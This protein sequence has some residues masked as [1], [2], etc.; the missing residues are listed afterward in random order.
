MRWLKRILL[1]F[2]VL[3]I[4]YLLGPTPTTPRYDTALSTLPVQLPALEKQVELE[5]SKQKLKPGNNATIVW[6]DSSYSK[7][8]YAIVYLHGFS[9]SREEGN[10]VHTTIAKTF[11]CNLYLSR[12]A[13]HGLD[14]IEPMANLTAEQLWESAKE[15]YNIG[16]QLGNKVILMGTSTGG[17][18]ALQLAAMYPEVAGL[19]LMSPN[20]AIND[21][22][23]WLL[24]NPW[25][26]QIARLVRGSKN[27][28]ASNKTEEYK[29]YW[30]FRYRLESA[31]ELQEYLETAMVPATFAKIKQ[32]VLTLYY[33]KDEVHQDPVVKVLAMQ[34]MM[35][36]LGTQAEEKKEVA[37]PNG[38]N[39]V[40]GSSMLSGDVP[41]VEQAIT[42][43]MTGT[44]KLQP[45]FATEQVSEALKVNSAE[46][47]KAI[48]PA[49][50]LVKEL[51][52]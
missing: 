36:L 8:E 7:T 48:R 24:N 50:K 27:N 13:A 38:G 46:V 30:Y 26:L 51:S 23:A 1:I 33:Y 35:Q 47:M 11:G 16:R 14:T 3:V 49:R 20:I 18:L 45:R 4:L 41:G 6:A 19:I 44:M 42:N 28:E 9:A 32:P 29:R 21:P 22:Y 17:S 10:P 34:Q 39:H 43:F 12:L 40:L 15:A 37:I 52:R 31:V 2:I 5:E 25:G